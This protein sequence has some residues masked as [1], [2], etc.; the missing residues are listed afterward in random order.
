MRAS[1]LATAQQQIPDQLSS[2]GVFFERLFGNGRAKHHHSA[3]LPPGDQL[4]LSLI[5]RPLFLQI[6]Q[7]RAVQLERHQKPFPKGQY[8]ARRAGSQDGGRAVRS[9]QGRN[10]PTQP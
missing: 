10:G 2:D 4:F 6:C 7:C 5:Q 1:V 8:D 9:G 3:G